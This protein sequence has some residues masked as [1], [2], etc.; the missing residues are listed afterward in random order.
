MN[1]KEEHD[2][3]EE[4]VRLAK[5]ALTDAEKECERAENV[6]R[7]RARELIAETKRK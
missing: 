2:I 6:K 4:R 5:I 1:W 3:L 7:A